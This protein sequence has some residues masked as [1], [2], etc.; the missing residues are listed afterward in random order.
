MTTKSALKILNEMF[1]LDPVATT[2]LFKIG[3]TINNSLADH[4]TIMC[5]ENEIGQ[6]FLRILGVINGILG[7]GKEKLIAAKYDE[8]T[9]KLVGFQYYKPPRKEKQYD[10]KK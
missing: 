4:P 7:A 6:T 10:N 8:D 2:E 5:D 1:K 3:V 9:D